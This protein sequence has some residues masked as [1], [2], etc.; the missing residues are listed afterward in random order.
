MGLGFLTFITVRDELFI[1]VYILKLMK[2][3]NV[4]VSDQIVITEIFGSPFMR[5]ASIV[6]GLI[7]GMIV[8]GPAGY[9]D[10]STITSSPAIT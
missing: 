4:F 3:S 1:C 5:N 9:V 2:I 8:A 7:V 6:I 10:G